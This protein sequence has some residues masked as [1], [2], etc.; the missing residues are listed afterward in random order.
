MEF[1]IRW[2]SSLLVAALFFQSCS[3]YYRTP[4]SLENVA[5]KNAKVKMIRTNGT[6]VILKRVEHTDN[7]YV[8]F[9][10]IHKA[11]TTVPLDPNDIQSLRLQNKPLSTLATIGMVVLIVSV[12][13]LVIFAISY[14][15]GTSYSLGEGT[16]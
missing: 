10:K 7:G 12:V 16:F 8:G 11:M 15:S 2:V 14:G 13:G 6:K 4:T 5:G 3:A 9:T 1:Y